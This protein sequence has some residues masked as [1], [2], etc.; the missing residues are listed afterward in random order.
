MAKLFHA[1][2]EW[3]RAGLSPF[4]EVLTKSRGGDYLLYWELK[5]KHDDSIK[6]TPYQDQSKISQKIAKMSI[7]GEK[8][9]INISGLKAQFLNVICQ[10]QAENLIF[11]IKLVSCLTNPSFFSLKNDQN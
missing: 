1:D 2:G 10:I 7:V 3:G 4:P 5:C 9:F 6:F 8:Y 11:Q